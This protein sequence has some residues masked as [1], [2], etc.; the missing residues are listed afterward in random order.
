MAGGRERARC[1]LRVGAGADDRRV[2]HAAVLLV[3]HA[4]GGGPGRQ[5]ARAVERRTSDG[6]VFVVVDRGKGD[7]LRTPLRDA[8]AAMFEFARDS[9]LSTAPVGL[10][11]LVGHEFIA[12]LPGEGLSAA[13]DQ[14]DVRGAFQD[15]SRQDDRIADVLQAGDRAGVQ[16]ATVHD[17]SV[18]LAGALRIHDGAMT[19]V[20]ERRVFHD[21]DRATTASRHEPPSSS[22]A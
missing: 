3:R 1:V 15:V 6:A 2:A 14:H 7:P 19:C 10:K 17:R 13:A 16:R 22:T 5:I 18:E 12:E 20:E 4:A 8:G 9:Q 11:I 21:L